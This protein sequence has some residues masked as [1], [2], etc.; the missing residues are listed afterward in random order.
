MKRKKSIGLLLLLMSIV[1]VSC[2]NDKI[3]NAD[4]IIS[5]S[6]F[7]IEPGVADTTLKVKMYYNNEWTT[8]FDDPSWCSVFPANGQAPE[9]NKLDSII[10]TINVK[11]NVSTSQRENTMTISSGSTQN[12]VFILQK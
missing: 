1:S 12:F 2:L 3:E 9:G 7:V 11:Q 5:P 4:I 6:A 8:K 10:L